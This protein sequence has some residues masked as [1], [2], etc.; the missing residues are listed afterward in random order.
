M[1]LVAATAVNNPQ[2]NICNN[3]G[4]NEVDNVNND[5]ASE[6]YSRT[7]IMA[8][9]NSLYFK[10]VQ[11]KSLFDY[12]FYTTRQ[13]YDGLTTY[14]PRLHDRVTFGAFSK[15]ITGANFRPKISTR[16]NDKPVNDRQ[17]Y[18]IKENAVGNI[19]ETTSAFRPAS[20]SIME[21]E[22][23]MNKRNVNVMDNL[24]VC[25]GNAQQMVHFLMHITKYVQFYVIFYAGLLNRPDDVECFLRACVMVKVLTIDDDSH[26]ESIDRYALLHGNKEK[27]RKFKSRNGCIKR[28]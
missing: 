9:I 21:T 10:K 14:L 15:L 3:K 23:N 16:M 27:L 2:S 25:D 28:S 13:I 20:K 5:S 17:L 1:K 24:T 11:A 8:I 7:S 26:I 19:N 4:E 22:F 12:G 6:N 18:K